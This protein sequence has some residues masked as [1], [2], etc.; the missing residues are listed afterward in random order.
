TIALGIGLNTAMFSVLNAMLLRPLS[1]PHTE[2]LFAFDRITA[3]NN[4]GGLSAAE[5]AD[6]VRDSTGV[7]ELTAYRFWGFN[8]SES[9][10]PADFPNSLRVSANFF[11]VLGVRPARGRSF[12]P[13]EDAPG[14]NNAVVISHQY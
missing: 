12:L 11:K 7:A 6:V 10:R 1:F 4:R 5:F 14:K 2:R 8:V 9:N 3:Q 13:D